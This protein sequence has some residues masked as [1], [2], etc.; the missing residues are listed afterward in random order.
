MTSARALNV[1]S[2]LSKLNTQGRCRRFAPPTQRLG[3][4]RRICRRLVLES[5]LAA[6]EDVKEIVTKSG[7]AGRPW[8]M[9]GKVAAES[10]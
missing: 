1:G 5:G 8:A 7:Q 2:A 3:I 10:C 4:Q 6:L 9:P